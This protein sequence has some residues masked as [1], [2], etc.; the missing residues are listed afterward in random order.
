MVCPGFTDILSRRYYSRGG[1]DMEQGLLVRHRR[2]VNQRLCSYLT[3]VS[4]FQELAH[5][6]FG[7][8]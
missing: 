8:P 1:V 6:V 2:L 3:P 7:A 4:L 5:G